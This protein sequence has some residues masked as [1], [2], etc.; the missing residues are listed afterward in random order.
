MMT[1]FG[2][3]GSDADAFH[4]DVATMVVWSD[5]ATDETDGAGKDVSTTMKW[6][7]NYTYVDLPAPLGPSSANT[8]DEGMLKVTFS[9]TWTPP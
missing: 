6:S 9:T 7:R 4:K 2:A 8:V 5:V 3:V 1:G